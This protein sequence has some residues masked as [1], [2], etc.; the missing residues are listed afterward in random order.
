MPCAPIPLTILIGIP[1]CGKSTIARQWQHREL[2]RVVVSTDQ[3]R[4]KVFGDAATQGP[5]PEIWREVARQW[6][7]AIAQIKTGQRR[8]VL[9]DATH[10]NRRDRRRAIHFARQLGFTTIDGYWLDV[11]LEICLARNVR[12]SRR[13]PE[14]VIRRMHQQLQCHPPALSDGFDYLY[15]L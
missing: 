13:V 8:A 15:T 4:A 12:R 10:A 5:W 6:Q 2:G 11:P 3:I 14:A 9:Y 7:R 1:G